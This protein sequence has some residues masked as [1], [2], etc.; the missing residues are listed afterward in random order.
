M[1]IFPVKVPEGML[2]RWKNA[3]ETRGM[4]LARM[5]REAVNKDIEAHE[6]EERKAIV[7]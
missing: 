7:G 3:A 5:I 1:K 4:P 2:V 6:S